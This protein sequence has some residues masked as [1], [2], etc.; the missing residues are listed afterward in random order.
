[1]NLCQILPGKSLSICSQ[2]HYRAKTGLPV[3]T[4]FSAFKWT[5]LHDNVAAVREA[6]VAGRCMLGTI[7]SWLIYNLT[8][9]VNGEPN[10]LPVF[11]NRCER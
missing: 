1:M 8:G 6:K 7:D 11:S 2:D 5:W 3:S 10:L 4:Y 9:G